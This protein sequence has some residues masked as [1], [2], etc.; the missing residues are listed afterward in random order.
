MKVECVRAPLNSSVRRLVCTRN[1]M[2]SWLLLAI[3]IVALIA[4]SCTVPRFARTTS[5]QTSI[6]PFV[7]DPHNDK[8]IFVQGWDENELRKIFA[9]FVETYENDGYPAYSIEPHKQHDKLFRL[10]FP[11]DI[12]PLLFTFLINYIAY[13][14]DR[15]LTNRSIVVAGTTSLT[16]G[17]EGVDDSHIGHRALLYLPDNDQDHTVVYMHFTDGT[18]YGNSLSGLVWRRLNDARLSPDVTKL[19]GPI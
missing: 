11:N 6:N 8:A 5:P 2:M 4:L 10:Q 12:H 17:Y 13:P 15:D 18:T 16:R 19:V 1:K 9:D 7:P 3:A 14:F